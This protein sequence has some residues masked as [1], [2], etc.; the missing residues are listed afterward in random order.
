MPKLAD[1]PVNPLSR[2]TPEQLDALGKE[3]DALHDEV[4]AELGL[5]AT[6]IDELTTA[7]TI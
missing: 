4:Y 1:E 7:G 3:F 2:L 5:S 6:E